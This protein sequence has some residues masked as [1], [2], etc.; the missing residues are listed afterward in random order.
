[1]VSNL[2]SQG[3]LFIVSIIIAKELPIDSFGMYRLILSIPIYFT[4]V[5]LGTDLTLMYRLPLAVSSGKKSVKGLI[6]TSLSFVILML[7]LAFPIAFLFYKINLLSIGIYWLYAYAIVFLTIINSMQENILLSFRKY[8][9]LS[10]S[11]IIHSFTYLI[12]IL[13]CIFVEINIHNILISIILSMLFKTIILRYRFPIKYSFKFPKKSVLKLIKFGFIIKLNS[14]LFILIESLPILFIA[15]FYSLED[16]GIYGFALISIVAFTSLTST[17]GQFFMPKILSAINDKELKQDNINLFGF[18]MFFTFGLLGVVSILLVF[19]FLMNYYYNAKY[20][21]AWWIIIIF[22][23]YRLMY[24][25]F[26]VNGNKLINDKKSLKFT[27]IISLAISLQILLL[28]LAAYLEVSILFYALINLIIMTILSLS[29][30]SITTKYNLS[31]YFKHFILLISGLLFVLIV[32]IIFEKDSIIFNKL[33]IL[34]VFLS[35]LIIARI[36]YKNI[37]NFNK[38]LSEKGMTV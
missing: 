37:I 20:N 22:L 38:N 35:I 34:I 8:S 10:L 23:I 19:S 13:L 6:A 29:I 32:G 31:A 16:V 28:S 30:F 24:Y 12:F 27:K 9:T 1:M 5:T 11:R 36:F 7:V 15:S 17:L 21:D 2:L 3:I 25:S 33:T 26:T 4:I 14:Y 18:K